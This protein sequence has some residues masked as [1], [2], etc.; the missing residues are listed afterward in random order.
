MNRLSKI[1]VLVAALSIP[2]T[3]MGAPAASAATTAPDRV[4]SVAANQVEAAATLTATRWYTQG[5]GR[6]V[7]VRN[8]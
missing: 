7:T 5:I 2:L 8:T 4:S 3:L 6:Y 1:G